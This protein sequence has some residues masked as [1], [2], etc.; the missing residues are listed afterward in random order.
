[1][2]LAWVREW[3]DDGYFVLAGLSPSE[4]TLGFSSD[5]VV[6]S[7]SLVPSNIEDARNLESNGLLLRADIHTL[8][9]L[10]LMTVDGDTMSVVLS[11]SLSGSHYS[12]LH[13]K[14]ITLPSD[15]SCRPNPDAL[16]M[17]RRIARL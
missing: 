5:H 4:E 11:P 14:K 15:P 7:T 1:M 6:D 17:H 10:G 8:F 2:G 3:R 16:N 12:E 13:G 9:D